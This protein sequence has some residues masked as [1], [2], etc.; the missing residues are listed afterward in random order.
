MPSRAHSAAPI[1]EMRRGFASKPQSESKG[2][3]DRRPD[4]CSGIGGC[5]AH[6]GIGY[7][8]TD[9]PR[10]VRPESLRLRSVRRSLDRLRESRYKFT[11]LYHWIVQARF[12]LEKYL[13]AQ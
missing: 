9:T 5:R 7:D 8:R 11:I 2:T 13:C 4:G 12:V 3:R 10:D 1:L 6:L